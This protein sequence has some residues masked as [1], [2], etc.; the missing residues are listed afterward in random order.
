MKYN[1]ESLEDK[2]LYYR[3][4]PE[5]KFEKNNYV[6]VMID[7]KNF[8]SKIKKRFK[9]PFDETFIR[10]MNET[11]AYVCSQVQGAKIA[12]TQSDEI[13]I[14]LT[15]FESA[16]T[17][18]FYD[19]RLCKMLSVIP[20]IATSYFNRA[21]INELCKTP[22]SSSDLAEM[23]SS[24]PLYCFDCKTW[25]IPDT[26][27]EETGEVLS[28]AYNNVFAWFLYRQ[29]DCIRNSKQQVAQTY[30]SHKTLNGKHT[31]EQIALLKEQKR[32]DWNTD[33]SDGEKYGRFI[34]KDNIIKQTVINGEIV[35]YERSVW[36]AHPAKPLTEECGRNMWD[37]FTFI[38]KKHLCECDTVLNDMKSLTDNEMY[39]APKMQAIVNAQKLLH[40]LDDADCVI[41]NADDISYTTWGSVVFDINVKDGGLVSLEIASNAYGFFTEGMK[42]GDYGKDET[43]WTFDSI[44]EELLE[45][46]KR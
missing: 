6:M 29:I 17:S 3:S 25:V 4:Y 27:N 46:L 12:F 45:L 22:C 19:Y 20:S 16:E 23:I 10:I 32:I 15:D 9:L 14:L 37:D 39:I 21:I 40:M 26:I 28:T 5:Q 7:G 38:P 35:D 36:E 2:C 30:L 8:S 44:P 43:K 42:S 1:F 31:D 34:Y 18:G 41:P 24:E 33:Y 13:S 11:A